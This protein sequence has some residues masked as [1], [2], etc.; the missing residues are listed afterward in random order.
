MSELQKQVEAELERIGMLCIFVPE[1]NKDMQ[2]GILHQI[3][4]EESIE[5]ISLLHENIVYGTGVTWKDL[6]D[7]ANKIKKAGKKL[8]KALEKRNG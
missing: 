5:T 7:T 2:L 4:P 6:N 3:C 8:E 1:G